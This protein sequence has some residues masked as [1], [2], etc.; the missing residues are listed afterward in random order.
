[1]SKRKKRVAP[2]GE[3]RKKLVDVVKAAEKPK[4]VR[5]RSRK[6]A[7]RFLAV[8]D[9]VQVVPYNGNDSGKMGTV[10]TTDKTSA[11]VWLEDGRQVLFLHTQLKQL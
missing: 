7:V 10:H 11:I 3:T 8:G 5:N 9:K 4:R 6:P 1:V 2:E